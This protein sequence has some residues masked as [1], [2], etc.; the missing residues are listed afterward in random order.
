MCQTALCPSE[1]VSQHHPQKQVFE[2]RAATYPLL[3]IVLCINNVH[4]SVLCEHSAIA[5]LR[6]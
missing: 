3:S 2:V 6:M 1:S 4:H 5:D